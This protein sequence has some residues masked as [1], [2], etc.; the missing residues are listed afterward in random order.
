MEKTA[1]AQM[2]IRTYFNRTSTEPAAG[3]KALA[4]LRRLE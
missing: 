4:L 1:N 2:N 3:A